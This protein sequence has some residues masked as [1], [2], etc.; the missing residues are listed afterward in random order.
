M[1][2][3]EPEKLRT[4]FGFV[5]GERWED[6][7]LAE[8]AGVRTCAQ[9]EQS[10]F[11]A[12]TP[13]DFEHHARQGHSVRVMLSSGQPLVAKPEDPDE[14]DSSDDSSIFVGLALPGHPHRQ[15][16]APVP[17]PTGP[18]DWSLPS[19]PSLEPAVPTKPVAPTE[20]LPT[21]RMERWVLVLLMLAAAALAALWWL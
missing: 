15:P 5:C 10:V 13:E 1:A 20:P 16:D 4:R 8:G 19:I 18:S 2:W 12:Q 11:A 6:M 21:R 3:N 17:P 14:L 9:G 7:S